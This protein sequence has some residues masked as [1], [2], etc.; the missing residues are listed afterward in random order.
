MREFANEADAD[1]QIGDYGEEG[2]AIDHTIER[3]GVT[4]QRY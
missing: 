3:G 1:E 4:P 2:G